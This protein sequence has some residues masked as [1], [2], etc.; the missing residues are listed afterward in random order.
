MP[1]SLPRIGIYCPGVGTGGPWRYVHA[2]LRGI[3]L[4]EFDVTVFSDL[5]SVYE[6]RPEVKVVTLSELHVE[7]VRPV[8]DVGATTKQRPRVRRLGLA[9]RL[10]MGTHREAGRLADVFRAHPLHLL[11]TQNTGCEESPIAAR[12]AGIPCVLGTF[13]VDSTYDLDR[14]RSG[15]AHRAVECVSN[16]CLHKA[17]AVSEAT[18]RDWVRRT[19]LDESRVITIYN[20]IDCTH[21]RRQSTQPA[22][23]R[24]LGLPDDDRLLISGVGRLDPAKGYSHL[25]DGFRLLATQFPTAMLVLAGTGQL[26]ESLKHQAA[27]AGLSDRV[28]FLGFQ[29]DVRDVYDASDVF[30]MSS[31]CETLGYALL[32][33]MAHELPTVATTVGGMP[34]VIVPGETGFLVPPRDP[35]ALA[36]AL[37]PLLESADLRIRLGKAGRERVMQHF[38][39]E[40]CVRKTID[41]Y[42]EMLLSVKQSKHRVKTAV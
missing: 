18:K 26:Q 30:V 33:A 8:S 39:E 2:V 3:D 22:A 23:R 19:W 1:Q 4:D 35:V 40:E 10:W 29:D 9:P 16:R 6:P 17:I 32:E 5:S 12:M 36:N 25:I 37:R 14:Q 38:T 34:E 13:H 15:F 28:R 24:K 7:S 41:V 11:H 21:F 20:G 42:R 27:V 31:L